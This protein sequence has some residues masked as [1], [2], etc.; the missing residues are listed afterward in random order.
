MSIIGKEYWCTFIFTPPTK[1]AIWCVQCYLD[2]NY[3]ILSFY[4]FKK[5][6]K[7]QIHIPFENFPK[8]VF[9]HFI[10]QRMSCKNIAY[11]FWRDHSSPSF[12]TVNC[13]NLTFN[14]FSCWLRVLC[15]V[16]SL[17]SKAFNWSSF[18]IDAY[19]LYSAPKSTRLK[20][21]NNSMSPSELTLDLLQIESNP[22]Y[23]TKDGP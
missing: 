18:I 17:Y 23:L 9:G 4:V 5:F 20:W 6:R 2:S 11:T 10:L 21:W 8:C 7:L 22:F 13:P 3:A 1:W 12:A 19:N 14:D 15:K 16:K